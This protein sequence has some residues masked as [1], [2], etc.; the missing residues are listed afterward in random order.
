MPIQFP[1]QVLFAVFSLRF[2]HLC[3]ELWFPVSQNPRRSWMASYLVTLGWG[4]GW[5]AVIRAPL[6]GASSGSSPL[7]L[8]VFCILEI[9]INLLVAVWLQVTP[10]GPSLLPLCSHESCHRLWC[11][12]RFSPKVSS[13]LVFTGPFSPFILGLFSVQPHPCCFNWNDTFH[14]FCSEFVSALSITSFPGTGMPLLDSLLRA[15]SLEEFGT[16]SKG[17]W[18]DSIWDNCILCLYKRALFLPQISQPLRNAEILLDYSLLW[19][20]LSILW[21]TSWVFGNSVLPA[22]PDLMWRA[23]QNSTPPLPSPRPSHAVFI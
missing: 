1:L 7:S 16:S 13:P 5:G 23:S 6:R 12:L 20:K 10:R 3:K 22:E 14:F 2:L 17:F 9:L 4:W 21:V 15:P 8:L 11:S 18:Q 19:S